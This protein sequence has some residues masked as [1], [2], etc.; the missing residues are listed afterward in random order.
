MLWR[1]NGLTVDVQNIFFVNREERYSKEESFDWFK[2]YEDLKPL[3][4]QHITSKDSRILMLGCGNSS[5]YS[6][7]QHGLLITLKIYWDGEQ[8]QLTL[9][10]TFFFFLKYWLALSE[11]MYDDGYH[12]I[13]NIDF[14]KTVIENMTE[15]C[16]DRVGME[17]KETALNHSSSKED[18]RHLTL[19]I[20]PLNW[21]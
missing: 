11:D 3:L 5:M 20:N 21:T 7:T 8:K 12:N 2:T 14:S 6:S 17:C 16:K 9:G 19:F 13:V 4:S 18:K 10:C 1:D 15:K